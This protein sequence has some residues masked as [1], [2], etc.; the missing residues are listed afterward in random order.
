MT[1]LSP[2]QVTVKDSA[3]KNF[4][5]KERKKE[6]GHP[7]LQYTKEKVEEFR[8]KEEMSRARMDAFLDRSKVPVRTSI[9]TRWKERKSQDKREEVFP[10]SKQKGSR[11]IRR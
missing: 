4:V 7:D 1:V 3:W 6:H 11:K 10:S 2:T 8:A 5:E 9:P